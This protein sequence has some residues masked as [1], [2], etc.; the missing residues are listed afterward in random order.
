MKLRLSEISAVSPVLVSML[1]TITVS[2][3]VPVR[4]APSSAPISSRFSRGV[5]AQ[6]SF[7][8]TLG[9]VALLEFPSDW[10]TLPTRSR[11][12]ITVCAARVVGTAMSKQSSPTN[13]DP[14]SRP[15]GVKLIGRSSLCEETTMQIQQDPSITTA[16][17]AISS[18]LGSTA[19]ARTE[20]RWVRPTYAPMASSP[21][22]SVMMNAPSLFRQTA[23]PGHVPR[24][25]L[26]WQPPCPSL[27]P[28][29]W[30]R[31]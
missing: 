26:R 6:G 2:V 10:N 27:P 5:S 30:L 28:F 4:P 23:P 20:L 31:N 3:R 9:R 14:A 18:R 15:F 13:A 7:L 12:A 21:A 1:A 8:S 16:P 29:R 22:L 25:E 17:V 24:R 19:S 11:W